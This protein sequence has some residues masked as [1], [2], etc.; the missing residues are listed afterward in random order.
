[1]HPITFEFLDND[2]SVA[3]YNCTTF[4][5]NFID[6]YRVFKINQYFKRTIKH[7]NLTH[8]QIVYTFL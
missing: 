5:Q 2:F 3:L 8:Y 4:D 1:M 7:T 6:H